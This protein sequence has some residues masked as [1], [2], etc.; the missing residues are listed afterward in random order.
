[1]TKYGY[2]T[3]PQPVGFFHEKLSS[4]NFNQLTPAQTWTGIVLIRT[5]EIQSALDV[6]RSKS[7]VAHSHIHSTLYVG[8]FTDKTLIYCRSD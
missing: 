2:K 5:L 6:T 4:L 8:P 7:S 3:H 1:M